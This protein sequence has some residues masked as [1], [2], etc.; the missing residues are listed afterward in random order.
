MAKFEV[1]KD[2]VGEYRWRL[3][4]INGKIIADSGE[5]YAN[6][7]DCEHGIQLIKAQ[8]PSAPINRLT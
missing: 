8:A 7:Q 6:K 4:E 2:T 1:Y 5:G 3:C